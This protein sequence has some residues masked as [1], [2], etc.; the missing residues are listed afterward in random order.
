MSAIRIVPSGHAPFPYQKAKD[1]LERLPGVSK[2]QTDIPSIIAAGAKVGWP[3]ALIDQ[4]WEWMHSGK[5]F[6]FAVPDGISCT[7][8]HDNI[9]FRFFDRDHAT[10]CLPLIHDLANQLGCRLLSQ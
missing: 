4:H 3:Q 8:W 5:C 1:L 10:R 6:D 9:F 2:S 7:L